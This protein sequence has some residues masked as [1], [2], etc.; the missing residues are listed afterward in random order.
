MMRL[1]WLLAS[2]VLVAFLVLATVPGSRRAWG[3]GTEGPAGPEGEYQRQLLEQI[4]NDPE[5]RA[6]LE[7]A[8]QAFQ[9]LSAQRQD[10]LRQV[11]RELHQNSARSARLGRVLERYNT[12][13]EHL[14]ADSRQ[15]IERAANAKERL[16]LIRDLRAQSWLPPKVWDELKKKSPGVRAAEIHRLRQQERESHENWVI[17][18]R[19][20][21][22]LFRDKSPATRLTSL[23]PVLNRFVDQYLT[24]F[25]S[26]Q[27][28]DRLARA[29]GRWPDF[30]R[31]LV[32]LMDKHA[33]LLPGPAT[34]PI[35]FEELPPDVRKALEKLDPESQ[36]HL[37]AAEG[38]WPSYAIVVMEVA[39]L[40]N[41]ELSSHP[42]L[43]PCLPKDLPGRVRGFVA[44]Q[45]INKMQSVLNRI[46]RERLLAAENKW[47][48]F[49]RTV[50]EMA[51]KYRLTLPPQGAFVQLPG[52]PQYWERYRTRPTIQPEAMPEVPAQTLVEFGL[53]DLGPRQRAALGV[54]FGDPLGLDRLKQ[55]YFRTRLGG[56]DKMPR[57]K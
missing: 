8:W 48:D 3:T 32:E 4:R 5:R 12:W 57:G 40:R 47:P 27:E 39:R 22:E 9:G 11:D 20:W 17:A 56:L 50:A 16:R 28:K 23:P 25:L 1:R 14:P 33:M 38:S 15:Q 7:R 18:F 30:P 52:R 21:D 10:S 19:N 45:M 43:W 37:Q 36:K 49:P 42:A 2:S 35:R 26:Q 29:E 13:L 51:R 31:T 41:I 6:R 24:P 46:D 55:A 53:F 34:G 54:S 44:R